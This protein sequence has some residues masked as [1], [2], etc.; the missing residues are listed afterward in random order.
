MKTS[1]EIASDGKAYVQITHA[2]KRLAFIETTHAEA[3]AIR[4]RVRAEITRAEIPV[5]KPL[6][7]A[8]RAEI[9]RGIADKFRTSQEP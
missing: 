4:D 8:R 9:A 5:N 2:G 7:E 3:E 6:A 1:I